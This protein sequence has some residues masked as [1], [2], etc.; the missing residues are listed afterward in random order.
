MQI[1]KMLAYGRSLF[2][3]EDDA[4]ACIALIGGFTPAVTNAIRLGT[5]H[6]PG[7]PQ[8]C[9][10]RYRREYRRGGESLLAGKRP[11][12]NVLGRAIICNSAKMN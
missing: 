2:H 3:D 5:R 1:G 10:Y 6:V 8:V 7:L 9:R 11:A 12:A 4:R